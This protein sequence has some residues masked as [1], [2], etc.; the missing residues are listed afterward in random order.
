MTWLK[1]TFGFYIL[2]LVLGFSGNLT[3]L[4]IIGR[5]KTRMWR[6][7]EMFILNL[8]ICDLLLITIYLPF[9]IYIF[10]VKFRPSVFYCKFIAS[11]ITV[12]LG[13]SIFTLTVMAVHRCCVITNP[14]SH[15]TI[16]Q[17]SIVRWLVLV[18]ILSIGLVV[19]KILVST[20]YAN[21][22]IQKWPNP[23]FKKLY[24]LGLFTARF[25][26]PLFIISYA[27]FRIAKDLARSPAPRFDLD[28][29]GQIKTRTA[30]RENIEVVKTLTMI[31][32][33]FVL[34][35]LPLRLTTIVMLFGDEDQVLIARAVR[36]Y[37]SILTIFHSCVNPIAY[38]TLTKNFRS[39]LARCARWFNPL[40]QCRLLQCKKNREEAGDILK[41][42]RISMEHLQNFKLN[43]LLS[44][45]TQ[46]AA[47]KV[48]VETAETTLF[49]VNSKAIYKNRE[50]KETAV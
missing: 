23:S 47:Q 2:T 19:P 39:W 28:E 40:I 42:A 24:T 8:A 35:M 10:L 37:A 12:A 6:P 49:Q 29:N 48:P 45:N 7:H 15:G 27:Y 34:C 46:D 4:I 41:R 50:R 20:A 30:R 44:G 31:V 32:V 36:R 22:C 13:A 21:R 17:R 33:L 38:G 25:A 5:K 11:L 16:S 43:Y 3:V 1:T 9:Q 14:F 18:W 26:I